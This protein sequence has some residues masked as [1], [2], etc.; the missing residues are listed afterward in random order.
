MFVFTPLLLA[1]TG[2]LSDP[3]LFA[4]ISGVTVQHVS[5]NGLKRAPLEQTGLKKG[6]DCLYDTVE[7]S[8][9]QT[10]ERQLLQETYLIQVKDKFGDRNF[11]LFT[12]RHMKGNK[13]K[14]YESRCIYDIV[15]MYGPKDV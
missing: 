10:E 9:E 5:S 7:V 15:K 8:Q 13:G 11:E 1:L 4:G 2:C 14:Y 12:D 6:I 3:P